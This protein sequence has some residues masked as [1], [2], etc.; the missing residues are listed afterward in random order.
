[1]HRNQL[2]FRTQE[3]IKIQFALL[4]GTVP[5]VRKMDVLG[6]SRHLYLKFEFLLLLIL[7]PWG[8]VRK[9]VKSPLCN[10][11]FLWKMTWLLQATTTFQ[12]LSAPMSILLNYH[13]GLDF[14]KYSRNQLIFEWQYSN[15]TSLFLGQCYSSGM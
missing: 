11:I 4:F 13:Y 10:R 2:Y 6:T 9:R 1:M 5:T 8:R 7:P 3:K 14:L 12:H 15:L